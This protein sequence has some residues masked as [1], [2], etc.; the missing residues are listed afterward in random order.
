MDKLRSANPGLN[1]VDKYEDSSGKRRVVGN[2]N[3]KKSQSYPM[4][5]G[6]AVAALYA[7]HHV[8]TIEIDDDDD[9][10]VKHTA[11]PSGPF[12]VCMMLGMQSLPSNK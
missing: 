7:K 10:D 12:C 2:S 6:R 8:E 11:L 9:D 4:Q 1:L 3:L 5:F